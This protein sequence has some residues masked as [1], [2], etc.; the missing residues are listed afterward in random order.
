[1][2]CLNVS[3]QAIHHLLQDELGN[4]QKC[5]NAAKDASRQGR[6]VVID[7]SGLQ[8]T[9]GINRKLDA[10]AT[11]MWHKGETGWKSQGLQ[12]VR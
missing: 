7:R 10:G 3:Q 5:V 12:A 6:N 1:M 11:S 4:R 9:H 8:S 2:P